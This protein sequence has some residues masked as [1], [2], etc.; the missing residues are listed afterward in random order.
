[1]E[2]R[3]EIPSQ[4]KKEGEKL[5]PQ[6]LVYRNNSLFEIWIP[7]IAKIIEELGHSV[8]IQAFPAGTPEEEIKKWIQE[9]SKS[10]KSKDVLCDGTVF[11]SGIGCTNKEFKLNLDE[12][13]RNTV[14]A[15]VE[16]DPTEDDVY[17]MNM[18]DAEG[19]KVDF[20]E[21][22]EWK[23]PRINREKFFEKR[24]EYSVALS[25]QYRQVLSNLPEKQRKELKFIL[26]TG[27]SG[28]VSLLDH[29]WQLKYLSEEG[30][31]RNNVIQELAENMK[32]VFDD[33]GIS[34]VK[35]IEDLPKKFSEQ[36]ISDLR[37]SKTYFVFDRHL[38]H[39]YVEKVPSLRLPL[40]N[41]VGDAQKNLHLVVDPQKVEEVLRKILTE[42][43]K[44][45]EDQN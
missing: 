35:I 28:K 12:L 43:L 11:E 40:G 25:N 9:N 37:S 31:D 34:K 44:P 22:Y 20:E 17:H 26:V 13:I 3:I 36:E 10:L 24:K 21:R 2:R 16:G 15:S 6:F 18:M 19:M 32:K 39:P 7:K 5:T 33:V 29:Y 38:E 4:E 30:D 27:K 8:E 1:M 23:L 41:F 42:A 45:K 14:R